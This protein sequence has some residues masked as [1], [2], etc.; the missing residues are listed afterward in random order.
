MFTVCNN[1]HFSVLF[2]QKR[3]S[4]TIRLGIEPRETHSVTAQ[5]GPR[6]TSMWES[7]LHSLDFLEADAE[8][9]LEYKI[10]VREQH[11]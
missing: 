2:S 11:L 8:M 7:L 4:W 9:D 6:E 5:C 10:F 3:F 1:V